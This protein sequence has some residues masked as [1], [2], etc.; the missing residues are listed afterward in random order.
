[1]DTWIAQADRSILARRAAGDTARRLEELRRRFGTPI[2]D[3]C[4]FSQGS[5][6]DVLD[7]DVDPARCFVDPACEW[8]PEQQ[9]QHANVGDVAYNLCMASRLRAEYG[10]G[11]STGAPALD[12]VADRSA[13]FF[14]R[15]PGDPQWGLRRRAATGGVD[16]D[17]VSRGEVLYTFGLREPAG[18]GASLVTLRMPNDVA[19][20]SIAVHR[21]YCGAVQQWMDQRR[22]TAKPGACSLSDECPLGMLCSSGACIVGTDPLDTAV[23]TCLRGTLA[24]MKQSERAARTAAEAARQRMNESVDRYD[25]A[26]RSCAILQEGQE[27]QAAAVEAHNATM[28]ELADWKLAMDVTANAASATKD[29]ASQ[30]NGASIGAVF[31]GGSAIGVACGAAA[32]EAAAKS[33]SDGLEYKMDQ[34]Q[35]KH[36]ATMMLIQADT[37]LRIC[38]NDAELYLAGTRS[39]SL[40]AAQAWQEYAVAALELRNAQATVA[41]LHSEGRLALAN[42]GAR[43]VPL[44][45]HDLWLDEKV[46]RFHRVM[47]LA[48]RMTYLAVRAVE[49]EFQYSSVERGNVIAATHPD[50]LES[51]LEGLKTQILTGGIGG[52]R[53]SQSPPTVVSLR[54]HILQLGDRTMAPEWSQ[55]MS[56]TERFRALL[57]STRFAVYDEDGEYRGQRIPFTVAPIGAFEL[58]NDNLA[59][60][61]S[62]FS[63][64]ERLWS[65]NIGLPGVSRED[66][67]SFTNVILE[68]RNTFYSQR[69]SSRGDEDPFQVASVRPR[70]NLFADPLVNGDAALSLNASTFEY[71][72]QT[73]DFARARIAA[74]AVGRAELEGEGVNMVPGESEELATRALFGDYAIFFPAGE[75]DGYGRPGGLELQTLEDVLIRFSYVSVAN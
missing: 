14:R 6:L 50:V 73:A 22:P 53:P 54:D 4:G 49:Y 68:Q 38:L 3:A 16:V 5:I 63:C 17:L 42:E 31:T 60:I 8:T 15:D 52:S 12:A 74:R 35:R 67:A 21:A 39:Q 32:V 28:Q 18:V 47:R 46:D 57:T 59:P 55:N 72:D 26:M 66:G 58:G 24:E 45:E 27:A 43:T 1:R 71:G 9:A 48:R 23:D 56:P 37:D 2:W 29:C 7:W 69:C 40:E 44:L 41:A 34:V 13:D 30:A 19:P 70:R 11:V 51:V 75:L 64:A 65:V 25:I 62:T 61:F 33:V 20:T 36:E 10:D